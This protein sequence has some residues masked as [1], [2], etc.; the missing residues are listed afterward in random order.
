MED[1]G[2]VGSKSALKAVGPF[3]ERDGLRDLD[4]EL[5][6]D[7][8]PLLEDL[9]PSDDPEDELDGLWDFLFLPPRP[10]D[11]AGDCEQD[12]DEDLDGD[13]FVLRLLTDGFPFAFLK[14]PRPSLDDDEG[15]L[16]SLPRLLA[17]VVSRSPSRAGLLDL[18]GARELLRRLSGDSDR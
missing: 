15:D 2:C 1:C 11:L 10:F 9:E 7:D 17:R 3:Y 4:L 5:L 8:D 6:R 13:L 18:N 14:L 16:L 12:S